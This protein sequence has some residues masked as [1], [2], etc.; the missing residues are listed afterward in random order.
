VSIPAFSGSGA[1]ATAFGDQLQEVVR[2][3]DASKPCGWIVD[4]RDN[5]GGNMWPMVAGIGP[6]LGEGTLGAFVGPD[7]ARQ[8]WYYRDGASGVRLSD[9][10]ESV[11]HRVSG[12]PYRLFRPDPPVAVIYGPR[13]ASSGEAVA[14][15]FRGRPLSRSFG[16]ETAGLSTANAGF[17]LSD[18]G[19]IFLTTSADADRTGRIYGGV[20]PPDH[21]VA[22]DVIDPS[23]TSDQAAQA[24]IAWLATQVACTT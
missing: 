17:P 22:W 24:A 9:G 10:R 19:V 3:V 20:L 16:R 12:P 15:A 14:V 7:S 6:V 21:A 2:L 13:T 4:L 11:A 1:A 8:T 5:P 18:G 23:S